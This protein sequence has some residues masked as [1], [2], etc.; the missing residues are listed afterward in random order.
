[1]LLSLILT[2]QP[3]L[4]SPPLFK[5]AKRDQKVESTMTKKMS[6]R[7]QLLR[8]VASKMR[9]KEISADLGFLKSVH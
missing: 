5:N 3:S 1:M 4:L 2:M 8:F 9:N 7:S 6:L